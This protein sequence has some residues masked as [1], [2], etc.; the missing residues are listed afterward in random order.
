MNAQEDNTERRRP[1]K[2]M[3]LGACSYEDF[4][5]RVSKVPFP[6]SFIS[7]LSDEENNR[8]LRTKNQLSA[9]GIENF[10]F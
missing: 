10:L 2:V 4:K 9:D 8:S 3:N 5:S 1:S 7:I 6:A